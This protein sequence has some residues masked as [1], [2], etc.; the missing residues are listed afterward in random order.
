VLVLVAVVDLC[1]ILEDEHDFS[2]SAFGVHCNMGVPPVIF[3]TWASRPC[4]GKDH[5]R[6]ARATVTTNPRTM[7]ERLSLF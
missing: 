4:I 7:I 1:R 6:D 2:A 3:V 5:G